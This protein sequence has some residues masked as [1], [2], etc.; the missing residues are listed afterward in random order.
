MAHPCGFF[1]VHSGVLTRFGQKWSK[2]VFSPCFCDTFSVLFRHL[3]N[4]FFRIYPKFILGPWLRPIF[5]VFACLHSLPMCPNPLH[6]LFFALFCHRIARCPIPTLC[7]HRRH[8][9]VQQAIDSVL[10]IIL[11]ITRLGVERA[12]SAGPLCLTQA[13]IT[14]ILRPTHRCSQLPN[15]RQNSLKTTRICIN[16]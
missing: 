12:S 14:M 10:G 6:A 9:C 3:W 4:F 16:I 5:S 7:Q 8:R 2:V 11:D 15:R 13:C 1:F